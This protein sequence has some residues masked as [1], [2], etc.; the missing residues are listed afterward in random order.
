MKNDLSNVS[1]I[2]ENRS[3]L[4]RNESSIEKIR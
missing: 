1:R 2:E 4:S 3:N